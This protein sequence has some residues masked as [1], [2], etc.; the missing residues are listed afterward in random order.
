MAE[1]E[2]HWQMTAWERL[3]LRELA[4]EASP[5][6]A[7]EVG[8]YQGGSLQ[9]L[10]KFATDV[11]SIDIDSTVPERLSGIFPNVRFCTGDSSAILANLF[12]E[13]AAAGR[14][15]GFILIDGDHSASGVSR[16]IR[17]VLQWRP[18][19]PCVVLMHDS[20]NP[21]CR[22]GIASAPWASSPYVQEIEVDFVPGVFH[23]A[24]H[25]T[26]AAAT[27]WGGFARALLTPEARQ[28]PLHV[29][30]SQQGLF[31][32]IYR[33]SSHRATSRLPR[34]LVRAVKRRLGPL[35]P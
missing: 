15:V 2:L 11:A 17:A 18:S 32:A 4:R 26:A 16:D 20:F 8:T 29:K 10:S 23:E 33:V 22:S 24:A 5:D 19:D 28:G 27:M 13:Y 30:T 21:D 1:T 7:I 25:D 14:S 31:N 9:V 35:R 3:A 12:T 6:V 34:R